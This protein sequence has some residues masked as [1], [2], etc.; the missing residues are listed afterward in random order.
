MIKRKE[1]WLAYAKPQRRQLFFYE[2]KVLDLTTFMSMHPG[3]K[4]ALTNY[5]FKDITDIIF[6]VYPHKKETTLITLLSYSI[7]M[8]PVTDMKQNTKIERQITPTKDRKKV[9]FVK[10][11]VEK[12]SKSKNSGVEEEGSLRSSRGKKMSSKSMN[13]GI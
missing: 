11:F 5:V 6:S 10:D 7:G 3:G 12:S 13:L 2:D 9:C 8:I 1:Q 4:K